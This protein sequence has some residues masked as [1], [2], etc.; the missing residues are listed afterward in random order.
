VTW[1]RECLG[2]DCSAL[3]SYRRGEAWIAYLSFRAVV[4]AASSPV[5]LADAEQRLREKVQARIEDIRALQEI[6]AA[7]EL[8]LVLESEREGEQ[9]RR[10]IR[11]MSKQRARLEL[12]LGV[13]GSLVFQ[14]AASGRSS[15][16]SRGESGEVEF[17]HVGDPVHG[18]DAPARP[19]PIPGQTPERE[20]EAALRADKAARVRALLR[21][22]GCRGELEDR[23]DALYCRAC[24]RN[25]ACFDGKPVLA[26]AADYDPSPLGVPESQ[27]PYG[28]QCLS[29]IEQYR[30]GWVLD[31]GSG[32]PSLGFYNVVHLDLA[33]YPQVDLV[34]D[35]AALPFADAS[36]DCVLSEAVLEHVRDPWGYVREL[37]R[38]LKPGGRVRLDVAF[39]QP[40]HGY[41]DHYF[42]MTRSGL[43]LILDQAGFV[44]EYLDVGPHQHPFVV[45]SMILNGF[46]QGTADG[47]K[48]DEILR[49]P[50]GE[51]IEKLASG[52]AAP[53]DGLDRE[54]VERLA[55]GFQCV[56]R[57]VNE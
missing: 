1:Y 29:L 55:S 6:S 2:E 44:A 41:P 9:I 42:N 13:D 27:N 31:C 5:S 45:L 49:M 17:L 35:G 19:R 50:I 46:V 8:N 26:L 21:C 10:F 11:P 37:A 39:L 28:Q 15:I 16:A 54:S 14:E 34:T 33:A 56:A 48:R 25:Y 43:E 53:F 38:V 40:Y 4:L 7:Q 52:Q 3:G 18:D 22:P 57:R 47:C 30:D 12:E 24:T 20:E 36:F 32:S 23:E 51:A